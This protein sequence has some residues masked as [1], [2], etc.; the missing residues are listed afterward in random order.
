M[1]L[2]TFLKID[3][4][5]G[6]CPRDGHKDEIE[7]ES[8]SFSIQQPSGGV[9]IAGG[10]AIGRAEFGDLEITK[11]VDLASA[12]LYLACS[13]GKVLKTALLTAQA[14]GGDK[15]QSYLKIDMKD[16][17]VTKCS[18]TGRKQDS[19]NKPIESVSF[20][21]G[22]IKWTYTQIDPSTGSAKGDMSAG[23][24]LKENKKV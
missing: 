24:N 7:L 4:L 15:P 21:Y 12:N 3:G 14:A 5:K 20:T 8:F 13:S 11:L 1:A 23:W 6:E 10:N 19:G 22:E 16:V 2:D 18:A 9:G 17:V